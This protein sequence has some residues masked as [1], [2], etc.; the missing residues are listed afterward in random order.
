MTTAAL[1]RH[2][3]CI[4]TPPPTPFSVFSSRPRLAGRLRAEG[5]FNPLLDEEL[6]HLAAGALIA[7]PRR[8][9]GQRN[10]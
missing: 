6:A 8:E 4:H 10:A 5:V 3:L 7:M 9:I 2:V 1:R